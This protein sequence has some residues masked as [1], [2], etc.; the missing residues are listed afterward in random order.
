[1]N[2]DRLRRLHQRGEAFFQGLSHMPPEHRQLLRRAWEEALKAGEA[3]D[4]RKEALNATLTVSRL[5]SILCLL[6][7]ITRTSHWLDGQGVWF[8]QARHCLL[9]A[10]GHAGADM[11]L[12]PPFLTVEPIDSP[13]YVPRARIPGTW[14]AQATPANL[15]LPV[16]LCPGNLL[17]EPW[18]WAT[19]FHE[20][21]HHLDAARRDTVEVLA[22]PELRGQPDTLGAWSGEK[23]VSE[24]IA[25]L[26]AGLLGGPGA[27]ETLKAAFTVKPMSSSHPSDEDRIRVLEAAWTGVRDG[28]VPTGTTPA[29]IVARALV[30]RFGT[31]RSR[32]VRDCAQADTAVEARLLPGRLYRQ[33]THGASPDALRETCQAAFASDQMV[34]PLWVLTEAHLKTLAGAMKNLVNT[35]VQP[36]TETLKV[37]PVDL[38][39]R[40][41]RISFVGATHGQLL[42][43]LKEARERRGRPHAHIE[44]FALADAPLR[45]LILG[46]R[47]GEVLIAERD[48]SLGALRDY[49]SQEGVPHRVFL[50]YQPYF[51][52]SYW[53]VEGVEARPASAPPAHIHVSSAQWGMDLRHA[54]GQD[55]ESPSGQPLPMAMQRRV[56]AL[57]HLRRLSREL[58]SS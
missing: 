51:F 10:V 50:F 5:D 36:G 14:L 55:L 2:E 48:A 33:H 53:D 13:L 52:A 47:S 7:R 49:L 43:K 29:D 56:E 45:E 28:K 35:R 9:D 57:T 34:R 3:G 31:W 42:P 16:V 4:A 46:G 6:E 27:V 54:V 32:V 21:G 22:M 8:G 39:I 40:H 15:P 24:V 17:E 44:L 30:E 12:P 25:D 19:L 1:M 20:L 18:A 23:W 11:P 37:P 38:M 41:E 58:T 26:Y